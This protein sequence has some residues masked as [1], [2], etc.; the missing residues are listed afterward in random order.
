M[1]ANN[2]FIFTNKLYIMYFKE[3][4]TQILIITKI[5]NILRNQRFILYHTVMQLL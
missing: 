2:Y 1:W 5:I 4:I 3:N